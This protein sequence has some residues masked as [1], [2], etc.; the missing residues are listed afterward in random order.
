MIKKKIGKK[1][2]D[3]L[4]MIDLCSGTGAFTHA[5]ESTKKVEVVFANDIE[6]SSKDIYDKNFNHKLTLGNICDI[7]CKNIPKHNILTAG[8]P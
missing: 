3:K 8:F 7:E 5:F 6:K 4:K 1:T 2:N